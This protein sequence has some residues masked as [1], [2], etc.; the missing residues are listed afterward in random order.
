MTLYFYFLVIYI[1]LGVCMC[2]VYGGCTSTCHAC[3]L[4][5][6]CVVMP[7]KDIGF[8][9]HISLNSLEAGSLAEP[10]ACHFD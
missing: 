1:V 6:V 2:C 8:L 10:E 5:S 7:E 4:V 3:T 9:Y